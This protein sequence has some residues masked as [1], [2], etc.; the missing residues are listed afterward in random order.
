[1]ANLV[2]GRLVLFRVD[3]LDGDSTQLAFSFHA[4]KAIVRK[5]ANLLSVGIG[6]GTESIGRIIPWYRRRLFS[7]RNAE[8]VGHS[9]QVSQGCRL[10]LAHDAGA[11]HLDRHLTGA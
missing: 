3:S 1:M 10:H 8:F 5:A 6:E 11:M 4:L 9:N 2:P 7:C